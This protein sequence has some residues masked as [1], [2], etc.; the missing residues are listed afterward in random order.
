MKY[1]ALNLLMFIVCQP[2]LG[3]VSG[4]LRTAAGQPIPFANVLLLKSPDSSLVKAALTDEAGH[5]QLAVSDT[6]TYFVRSSSIGYQNW[7]SPVFVLTSAQLS[8]ELVEQ[9]LRE[10]TRQLGEVVIRAQKPLYQQTAEGT[11]VNVESSVLSKGS[12]VIQ[13]LER[14]PGV[15]IDYR[16]NTITL[17]GKSGVTVLLNGKLMRMSMEQ[18][19]AFL[20]GLS[21]NDIEKIELLAT[22][23]ARYDAEGSAGVINIVLKK[24]T[25]LGTTGT[26]SLTGGYGVGEKGVG[27]I[28][29]T[30][31]QEAI[32]LYGSY[33]FVHDRSY[34]FLD[35]SSTQTMPL[36]GGPLR[37]LFS[38]QAH[39]VQNN[40][41]ATLGIDARLNAR[42]TLG[43]SLLYANLATASTAL[44]ERA[45]TIGPD[46]VLHFSSAVQGTNRWKNLLASTYLERQVGRQGK[47]TANLDYLHYTN[48]IPTEAH[49]TLSTGNSAE[50]GTGTALFAP[51]QRGT[52]QTTIQVGVA[53]VDYAHPLGKNVTMELG[54]KGVYT[55]DASMSDLTS[56]ING[57]WVRR[58]ATATAIHMWESIGAAYASL[59]AQLNPRTTLTVGARYEYSR[60]HMVERATQATL[61]DRRLSQLFPNLLVSRRVG[62]EAEWQLAYTKRISRPSYNELASFVNYKDRKSVV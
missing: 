35:G 43:G 48:A 46:S 8:K 34:S 26:Y 2:I 41:N 38:N 39:S 37:I 36:L 42:T 23:G 61:V 27:S 56:L 17:N 62:N 60:T 7:R 53:K 57:V 18:L 32:N 51:E 47:L 5:Y 15:S 12:S 29:L 22:P 20:G 33:T 45:F 21:A 31:N 9:I 28:S 30:H 54:G 14:A 4:H 40:H 24:S 59:Q 55:T 11:V 16:N 10:D 52:A 44:N 6:G 3:Q 13:V 1:F 50:V 58:S 49:N 19:V 25:K